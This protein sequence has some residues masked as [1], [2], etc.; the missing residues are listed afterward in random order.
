MNKDDSQNNA[1]WKNLYKK[2]TYIL[3]DSIYMEF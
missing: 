1:E 3:C 2:S